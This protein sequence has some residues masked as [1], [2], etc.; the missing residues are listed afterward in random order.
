[1]KDQTWLTK[2]LKSWLELGLF[3]IHEGT[4]SF[5]LS[6]LSTYTLFCNN[7]IDFIFQQEVFMRDLADN[8]KVDGSRKAGPNKNYIPE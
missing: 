5:D 6:M 2:E 8:N 1:M 3:G 4:D 7:F